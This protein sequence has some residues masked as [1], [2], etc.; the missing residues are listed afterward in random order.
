MNAFSCHSIV[1][2]FTKKIQLNKKKQMKIKVKNL[3]IYHFYNLGKN[4]QA[5]YENNFLHSFHP[6]SYF[7]M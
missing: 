5:I 4:L 7:K 3:Q 1:S 2:S 6:S